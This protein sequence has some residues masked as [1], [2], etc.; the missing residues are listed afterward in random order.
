MVFA[1]VMKKGDNVATLLDDCPV[2]TQV[3][4]SGDTDGGSLIVIENIR[5]N[6]KIALTDIF[7]THAVVKGG[8]SIG[9]ATASV[10]TGGWIHMHNCASRYDSRH[11]ESE[12]RAETAGAK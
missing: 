9:T 5:K 2:G 3:S 1:F 7:E 11:Y 4:L 12:V 8:V 6:H 10:K